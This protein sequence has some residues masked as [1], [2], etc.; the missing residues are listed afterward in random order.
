MR[1]ARFAGLA[2]ICLGAAAC[3]AS[4]AKAQTPASGLGI[5]AWY[6]FWQTPESDW[7][8]NVAAMAADG[9]RVAR[10]DAFWNTVE[11][12]APTAA[13][14]QYNWVPLDSIVSALAAHGI[15]WQPII[16]YGVSWDESVAGD[17]NSAPANVGYFA[18]YA[19]AL[20]QRYGPDGTFWKGHATVP[21][22]PVTSVEIWNEPNVNGTAMSADKYAALYAASRGA[23]RKVA[24]SVQTIVGGLETP[25][26]SYYEAVRAALG[27]ATPIDAVAIHPYA[28]NPADVLSAVDT[29]RQAMNAGGDADV[30]IDVTEFGWPTAGFATFVPS[31]TQTERASYLYE[32]I[33]GLANGDDD[34]QEILPYTWITS[35]ADL[36]DAQ[37]WFGLSNKGAGTASTAALASAYAEIANAQGTA[38]NPA[39]SL[40]S[41]LKTAGVITVKPGSKAT[42]SKKKKK[43]SK[44]K[45]S[46]AKKKVKK[47]IAAA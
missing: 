38:T 18:D 16:D 14:A 10:A 8:A 41:P 42:T 4:S 13:G 29:L 39:S 12:A 21:Y 40:P 22:V 30:P 37:D 17:T 11:P 36:A 3:G 5:N 25:A 44:K 32:T 7:S 20:V 35:E 33:A 9:V 23:I 28:D 6:L 43:K 34:V 27:T 1:W 2:S 15:R 46:T 24:P 26:A 47:R 19:A 45:K 31:I